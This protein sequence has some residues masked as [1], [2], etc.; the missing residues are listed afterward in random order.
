MMAW[1]PGIVVG[2]EVG[3]VGDGGMAV[4]PKLHERV[5]IGRLE[6]VL[7]QGVKGFL[8]GELR[9]GD[10]AVDGFLPEDV[11]LVLLPSTERVGD[12][13]KQ[14][15][16]AS[17]NQ[18]QDGEGG[19]IARGADVP[20][21]TEAAN[22]SID[23]EIREPDQGDEHGHGEGDAFVDVVKNVVAHF[24]SDD[25]EN[26]IR[27]KF[28]DGVIPNDDAGG[29]AEAGDVGIE[30]GNFFTGLHEEHARRGNVEVD[31]VGQLLQLSGKRGIAFLQRGKVIEDGIYPN[32]RDED[33]EDD[34][35]QRPQPEPEPPCARRDAN[36]AKEQKKQRR[37]DQDRKAQGLGLVER[38]TWPGLDRETVGAL[39]V[40]AVD[41]EW[42]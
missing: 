6:V 31:V 38:P 20:A 14:E 18:Q 17:E 11:G 26:L 34:D 30:A 42:Q 15:R 35:G 36:D 41:I 12:G 40:L 25:E 5:G 8:R 4:E 16:D 28:L 10:K 33:G 7:A 13:G 39:D 21:R 1:L 2:G 37:H 19:K 32:R 27:R 3:A 24:M 23:G 29:G 22:Q 9:I